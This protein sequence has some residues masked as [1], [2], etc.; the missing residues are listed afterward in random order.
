MHLRR[1]NACSKLSLGQS[2][3][4][5]TQTCGIQFDRPDPL[6]AELHAAI[7]TTLEAY[8]AQLPPADASHPLLGHRGCGGWPDHGLC[9]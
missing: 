5:G 7:Q 4:G 8:R 2:Q 1:L 9:A 6:F 3:R